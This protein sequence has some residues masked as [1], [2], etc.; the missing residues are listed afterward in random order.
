MGALEWLAWCGD[1][2]VRAVNVQCSHSRLMA[3]LEA[4]R[5][6]TLRLVATRNG[7]TSPAPQVLRDFPPRLFCV[8]LAVQPSLEF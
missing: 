4:P 3:E 2:L 1:R 5:P 6:S 7:L 8:V